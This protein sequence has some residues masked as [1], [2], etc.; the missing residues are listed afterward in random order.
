MRDPSVPLP[1][2]VEHGKGRGSGPD[3]RPVSAVRYVVAA[4][5]AALVCLA[6]AVP[7]M[8]NGYPLLFPDSIG[9][10]HAGESALKASQ[11]KIAGPG[12][13]GPS[14]SAPAKLANQ[15]IDGISTARSVYYGVFFVLLFKL[16]GAWG[17]AVAQVIIVA[18]STLLAFRTISGATFVQG[19]LATAALAVA[20]GLGV[21]TV[22][23]MPDVFAGLML[24]ALAVM[25]GCRERLGRAGYLYWLGLLLVCCLFHKAN[26]AVA[27][28][29]ILFYAVI[30]LVRRKRLTPLLLP[31]AALAVA[32]MAHKAVIMVVESMTNRPTLEL[33]FLLARM[34]GDGTAG[35]YLA[36]HCP[37]PGLEMCRFASRLPMTSNEFLWSRDPQHGVMKTVPL[38]EARLI[39]QQEN[40]VVA[41]VLREHPGAQLRASLVNSLRQLIDVGANEY[42][43]GPNAPPEATPTLREFLIDFQHSAVARKQMPFVAISQLMKVTYA[44]AAILLLVGLVRQWRRRAGDPRAWGPALTMVVILL[45]AGVVINAA[46][47]GAVSGDFDRYQ[48]RVAWLLP[49][50]AICIA[51]SRRRAGTAS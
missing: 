44:V 32:F 34:V 28:V 42:A 5:C 24:L 17:I 21:F 49:F 23:A 19:A 38:A 48:G 47:S 27:A 25:L 39:A 20:G 40:T 51:F 10:F 14:H 45:F 9:Y 46:V 43:I 41:G 18:T 3:I 16:V 33:P 26:V 36:D 29:V 12:K 31:V 7:G 8:I 6:L 15:D 37:D 11:D 35:K 1:D 22:A 4:V 2:A 30:L 13:A 50:A